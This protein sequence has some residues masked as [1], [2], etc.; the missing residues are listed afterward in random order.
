MTIKQ[1]LEQ[2][3][4]EIKR[5][6]EERNRSYTL[7]GIFNRPLSCR[8]HYVVAPDAR[9]CANRAEKPTVTTLEMPDLLTESIV[10]MLG[11][12]PTELRDH[13]L[14]RLLGSALGVEALPDSAKPENNPA[15]TQ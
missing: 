10:R 3:R 11:D 2:A 12:G 9:G 6:V 1:E 14:P 7:D 15:K 4:A 5:L 8:A 13:L